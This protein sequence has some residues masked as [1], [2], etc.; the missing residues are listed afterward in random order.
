ML[1]LAAF[2]D[3]ISPDLDVQIEHCKKN[4]VTHIELRGVAGKNV[5]DFDQA[6]RAEIKHALA[7]N[8]LGVAC[9]GSPI[10]KVKLNESFDAH[11]ERFKVAVDMAEFFGAPLVRIFSYYPAEGATH[12]DLVA[13][14]RDEVILRTQK[15]VD[16]LRGR[17]PVLV[18][19]N[20]LDIFGE[21]GAQ[22]L[23]LLR[24]INSPKLRAAFD[25]SNFVLAGEDPL[26]N[27]PLL[28][29]YAIHFHI[30]DAVKSSRKILPAGLGEGHIAEVLKDA[31][32]SGY[33]GFLS[34]EPH[35]SAAGQFSGFS[36]PDLFKTAADALRQ[37]AGEN[38]IPLAS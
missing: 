9:I 5:L 11:F 1:K 31:Y 19:E 28:K 3:E 27:W 33:R 6:L 18:H 17:T 36:G 32:A 24:T 29:P 7:D 37:L 30:K 13:K 10:G 4:G 16:Y 26:K 15:K 38:G 2:A 12:A 35:L 23:D 21:K 25:F 20:E 8:G 22:C 14:G 34:L